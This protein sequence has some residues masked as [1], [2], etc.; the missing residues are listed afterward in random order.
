MTG[1]ELARFERC[2]VLTVVPRSAT[3]LALGDDPALL[4]RHRA[5]EFLPA[6]GTVD[7]LADAYAREGLDVEARTEV[8]I[9][10]SG[11]PALLAEVFGHPVRPVRNKYIRETVRHEFAAAG[12]LRSRLHSELVAEVRIPRAGFELGVDATPPLPRD[13]RY[14]RLPEDAVRLAGA[15]RPHAA[16]VRGD[17]VRVVMVDTGLYDHPHHRAHGYRTRVVPALSALDPAV[18]E[19]GHGTAMSA[20]LLAVA[21]GADL[22]MVKMAC[23]SFSFPLAAFQRAVELAPD[24]ISCSW[25]TLRAEPHL[26]LE[27]A[28]AV[29]RGI[30]VL[31]AAGNGS[32]DRRTAMFQS[33]ATPG[34]ITV[35]GVHVGPDGRR[36]AA[37]LASSY[38]SDVFPGRRVPDLSGPCGMLPHG[39]YVVFPTQPG[40]MF[41]RRNSAYDGTAPDDGWLVSSGT[42]GATAYAAG[43]V[44]LAVQQGIGK[45]RALTAADLADACLPVTRGRTLT[46]DDCGGTCPNEAVGHGLLTASLPAA[47]GFR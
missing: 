30:T 24:V 34:A 40:C 43:V 23:E 13:A 26:H 29:R 11:A 12:P 7:R 17:G 2:G 9:T 3:G 27:I 14:L 19:R 28:N 16:G 32:T 1:E 21:P 41:D 35:G 44:A 37:D 18:D 36:Q 42:S 8:G 31:F 4:L 5:E 25:G 15:G 20:F 33:V 39:D 45:G 46:G 38:R 10:V 22:T 6:P 47:P